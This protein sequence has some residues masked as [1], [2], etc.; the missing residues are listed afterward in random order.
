MFS[1]RA[2]AAR[3]FL[4][5]DGRSDVTVRGGSLK[6]QKVFGIVKKGSGKRER[7]FSDFLLEAKLI[8]VLLAS[9]MECKW[10]HFLSM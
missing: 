1:G 7:P 10:Q 8:E 4:F 3:D 6:E 2:N 9:L 5:F